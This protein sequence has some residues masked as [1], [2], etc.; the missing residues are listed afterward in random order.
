MSKNIKPSKGYEHDNQVDER[1]KQESLKKEKKSIHSWVPLC[2]FFPYN[3]GGVKLKVTG[4][5]AT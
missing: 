1:T 3:T 4:H 5:T 2:P